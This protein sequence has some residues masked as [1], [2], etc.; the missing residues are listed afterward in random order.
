MTDLNEFME[1]LSS[2]NPVPGGGSVAALECALGASLLA[3]VTNLTLGRRKYAEAEE[4][5]TQVREEALLLQARAM[6]LAEE[7]VEAYGRVARVLG[8]PRE[9]DAEKEAR[10]EHM[11]AALKGA[12]APPLET[13]AA[14]ARVLDL[15]AE[16]MVIGNR[17][18][19]SDVGSAAG[20]ARAG[21][22]AALLN[23]EINLASI[24]DAEWVQDVRRTVGTFPPIAE[25]A[26]TIAT[27]VLAAIRS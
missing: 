17:S 1:Q 15:A 14:A 25:R 26:D 13:M 22:D 8:M 9:T 7:D 24:S 12:I 6:S 21:F 11:Q 3:M 2:A 4:R 20:A 5:V 23:V 27:Y 19:I 18:A 10:R 16:L